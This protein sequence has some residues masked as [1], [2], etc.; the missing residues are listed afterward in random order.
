MD[1]DVRVPVQANRTTL[2]LR[3][4]G[5]APGAYDP[6]GP[7]AA[8]AWTMPSASRNLHPGEKDNTPAPGEYTTAVRLWIVLYRVCLRH[9]S[10]HDRHRLAGHLVHCPCDSWWLRRP[11]SRPDAL[12]ATVCLPLSGSEQSFHGDTPTTASRGAALLPAMG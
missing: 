12:P 4:D 5:P 1:L 9:G 6:G 11:D 3:T 2:S 7:G 10:L 8:P